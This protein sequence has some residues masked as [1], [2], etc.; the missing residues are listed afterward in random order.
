MTQHIMVDAIAAHDFPHG[1][2]VRIE[3]GRAY[4]ELDLSKIHG[5]TKRPPQAG[6]A[7]DHLEGERLRVLTDGGQ[8]S[9]MPGGSRW[10]DLRDGKVIS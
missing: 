8:L 2:P 3:D 5:V 1:S 9:A 7:T 4:L 6:A 10:T